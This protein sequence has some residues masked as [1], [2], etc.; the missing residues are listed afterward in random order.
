MATVKQQTRILA[1]RA[2]EETCKTIERIAAQRT[3]RTGKR[4]T[5]TD[6]LR[7]AV[8]EKIKRETKS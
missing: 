4:C 6:L 8:A 5:T 1:L 3:I 7:E 2:P